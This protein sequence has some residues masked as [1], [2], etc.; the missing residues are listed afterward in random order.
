MGIL[1]FG[2]IMEI[3]LTDQAGSGKYV[4]SLGLFDIGSAYDWYACPLMK[5]TKSC[6][7]HIVVF[8]TVVNTTM[9]Q[10]GGQ[11]PD[12]D[13]TALIG[14]IMDLLPVFHRFINPIVN[15]AEANEKAL[16]ENQI[17]ILA[18]L[19]IN[20]PLNPGTISLM[21]NI[22]KGSLTRMLKSLIGFGFVSKS[23][24]GRDDRKYVV[25][26]TRAGRMFFDTHTRR[27]ERDLSV[28]FADMEENE[29]HAV[30]AGLTILNSYLGKRGQNDERS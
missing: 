7:C 21:L 25:G 23:D 10:T 5:L 13:S 20:G 18:V 9:W 8:T 17:K 14:S 11:M 19:S 30:L 4:I 12:Q 22:Q 29:K 2:E 15:R 3:S 26:L 1:V 27:C 28:L 16:F 6:H 24:D